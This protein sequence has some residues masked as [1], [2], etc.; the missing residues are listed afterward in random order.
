VELTREHDNAHT[1]T[2]TL[3]HTIHAHSCT[4]IYTYMCSQAHRPMYA[5]EEKHID[6]FCPS[7][8]ELSKSEQGDPAIFG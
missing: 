3:T 8:G 4:H 6:R 7:L 1:H 5:Q 2:H